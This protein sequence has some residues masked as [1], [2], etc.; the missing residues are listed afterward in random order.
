MTDAQLEMRFRELRREFPTFREALVIGTLRSSG[1]HVT[2]DRVRCAIHD[3]NEEE[4]PP[5]HPL[6]AFS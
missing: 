5:T 3:V 4:H 6:F 1:H 2:R